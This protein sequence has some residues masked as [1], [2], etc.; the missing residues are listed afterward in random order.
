M[1]DFSSEAPCCNQKKTSEV[2]AVCTCRGIARK[3]KNR[4]WR[5]LQIELAFRKRKTTLCHG[6]I[7]FFEGR[8][9]SRRREKDGMTLDEQ[10]KKCRRGVDTGSSDDDNGC[11]WTM[12]RLD[13]IPQW[14]QGD[15]GVSSEGTI[16]VCP[17]QSRVT[18][19]IL[20]LKMEFTINSNLTYVPTRRSRS[21]DEWLFLSLRVMGHVHFTF[22][23]HSPS[24][25]HSSVFFTAALDGSAVVCLAVGWML[26]VHSESS[27]TSFT[28][29]SL[30]L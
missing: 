24:E 25:D 14:P 26:F 4:I 20:D 3:C 18:G 30:I 9:K 8:R 7:S 12:R 2:V 19:N 28:D 15:S 11:L 6:R 17:S 16:G 13:G 29:V 21:R 27:L 23:K 1:S 5:E 10:C 22:Q